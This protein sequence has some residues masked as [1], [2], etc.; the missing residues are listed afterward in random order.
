VLL[1]ALIQLALNHVRHGELL[2]LVAPLS[3]APAL[4]RGLYSGSFPAFSAGG[5]RATAFI[6]AALAL[7]ATIWA[8]RTDVAPPAGVAP[9]AAVTAAREAGLLNEPVLNDFNFGGFLI[10]SGVPVF[11]DGRADLY[12]A[13]FLSRYLEAVSLTLPDSLDNVL[14]QYGIGWTLLQPGTPAAVLLDRMPAWTR[15]YADEY[16]VVHR[17]VPPI[18]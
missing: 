13:A 9:V 17:R 11:I 1:V 7:S 16:A 3:L 10:A 8:S 6:T 5:I 2:G 4:A 12:G 14:D 15:L 18:R